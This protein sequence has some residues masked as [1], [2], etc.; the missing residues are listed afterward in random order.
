MGDPAVNQALVSNGTISQ[1]FANL[2]S[3]RNASGT[4]VA[5]KEMANEL[6][7]FGTSVEAQKAVVRRL[8]AEASN[9]HGALVE[10]NKELYKIIDPLETSVQNPNRELNNN[11]DISNLD[12]S[13][14]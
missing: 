12:F 6:I 11:I 14:E 2:I 3:I 1:E 4:N 7:R 9:I 8:Q 10:Q 13:I 5:D